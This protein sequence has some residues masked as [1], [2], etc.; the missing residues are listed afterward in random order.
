MNL[1]LVL[2]LEGARSSPSEESL[3][4]SSI[5]LDNVLKI[6][7]NYRLSR[8]RP[9]RNFKFQI[10]RAV[11]D[12]KFTFFLGKNSVHNFHSIADASEI[13]LFA[14]SILNNYYSVIAQKCILNKPIQI[15]LIVVYK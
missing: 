2:C 6:R 9:L 7:F 10:A 3:D 8:S 12:S 1:L 13:A 11:V 15:V 14:K 5:L 4:I